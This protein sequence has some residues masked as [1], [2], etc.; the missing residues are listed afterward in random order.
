[1]TTGLTTDEMQRPP[2]Q[3]AVV[4]DGDAVLQPGRVGASRMVPLS[5][6]ER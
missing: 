6:R 4:F 5:E 3:T 2:L 1:M